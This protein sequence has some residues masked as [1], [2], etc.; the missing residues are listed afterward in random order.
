MSA[1]ASSTVITLQ[2]RDLHEL[3]ACACA[4]R[5]RHGL[6]GGQRL[7]RGGI[8][9]HDVAIGER[10]AGLIFDVDRDLHTQR[11]QSR[12][13]GLHGLIDERRHRVAAHAGG[14]RQQNRRPDLDRPLRIRRLADKH[15]P[16]LHAVARPPVADLDFEVWILARIDVL[17]IGPHKTGHHIL[18]PSSRRGQGK[19][20]NRNTGN[21]RSR[22]AP[23]RCR[24]CLR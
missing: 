18:L 7:A 14:D 11:V 8:G 3:H 4:H 1:M 5:Q 9:R 17:I 12:L 20:V 13:C 19:R 2:R 16:I 22:R 23:A 10:R 21:T 15:A 6:P 24:Q